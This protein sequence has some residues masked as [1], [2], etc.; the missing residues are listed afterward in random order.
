MRARQIMTT[1][2]VTGI[3]VQKVSLLS[4]FLS[5]IKREYY[6]KN[7]ET[8]KVTYLIWPDQTEE[9]SS[10]G[11]SWNYFF[12]VHQDCID[13]VPHHLHWNNARKW[14]VSVCKA[15]SQSF[16]ESNEPNVCAVAQLVFF[17]N[18]LTF[19]WA[20]PSS[21]PCSRSQQTPSARVRL[22][23][24]WRRWAGLRSGDTETPWWRSQGHH[25][26]RLPATPR[27]GWGSRRWRWQG[28]LAPRGEGIS[29]R[30]A[31][32]HIVVLLFGFSAN[33]QHLSQI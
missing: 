16:S 18:Q 11:W 6:R 26:R 12:F 2:M 22:G 8:F 20:A 1:F 28:R 30:S 27:P 17:S 23:P 4:C 31:S 9:S 7:T 21:S 24:C 19:L 33:F 32:Q 15:F 14:S 3:L 13:L 29:I 10:S 25:P 5:S